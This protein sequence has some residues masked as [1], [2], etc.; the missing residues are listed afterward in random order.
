[1]NAAEELKSKENGRQDRKSS[2]F[3]MLVKKSEHDKLE[4]FCVMYESNGWGKGVGSAGGEDGIVGGVGWLAAVVD[5]V[6]DDTV[7]DTA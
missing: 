4:K 5:D 6:A 2:V 1:M 3:V 7:D